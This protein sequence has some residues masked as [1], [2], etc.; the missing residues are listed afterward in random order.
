MAAYPTI[1][2]AF[3]SKPEVRGRLLNFARK[4]A[5][6]NDARPDLELVTEWE[7]SELANGHLPAA[8]IMEIENGDGG[9]WYE[10]I[11][12]PNCSHLCEKCR[13]EI[14]RGM[15]EFGE[16]AIGAFADSSGGE[17]ERLRRELRQLAATMSSAVNSIN[18]R[19]PG[20]QRPA[21]LGATSH[22]PTG[23]GARKTLPPAGVVRIPMREMHHS[24][25]I[26][27]IEAI[28]TD[29]DDGHE[30]LSAGDNPHADGDR[31]YRS[32]SLCGKSRAEHA[33]R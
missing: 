19:L 17:M 25:G 12:G 6:D 22:D 28:E 32:C 2:T 31:A 14:D 20:E 33:K 26:D 8:V 1:Q 27:K 29:P 24:Q 15:S 13:A 21:E 18:A 23:L 10:A 7:A 5:G 4:D 9:I 30:Y 11:S 16:G 3:S